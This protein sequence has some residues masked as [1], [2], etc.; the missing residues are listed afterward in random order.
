MALCMQISLPP[1]MPYRKTI[2]TISCRN[3]IDP[4][5]V[6][7]VIWTESRFRAKM[8]RTEKDGHLSV[9]LMQIKRST[10]R[11]IGFRGP[12]RKLMIPW[13]NV[14]Y[15]VKYLKNR[16]RHYSYGWDS[17]SAYN[18][19]RPLWS[20][21]RFRYLNHGY[22]LSVWRHYRNLCHGSV[23]I[24]PEKWHSEEW[25]IQMALLTRPVRQ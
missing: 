17:V 21:T 25:P 6:A 1:E 12:L 2:Q 3:G 11:E 10:A 8:I 20:R 9:G 7:S 5:L 4:R 14:F 18:G 16:I 23:V 15:G 22:V 13:I 24:R 19:G